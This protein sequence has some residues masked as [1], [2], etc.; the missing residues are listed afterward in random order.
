[1]PVTTSALPEADA[2]AEVLGMLFGDSTPVVASDSHAAGHMGVFSTPDD[3]EACL[4]ICDAN[5]ACLG[6]A[7]LLMVPAGGAKDMAASGDRTEAISEGFYEI[8]NICS[9]LYPASTDVPVTLQEL[10]TDQDYTPNTEAY[11]NIVS[12]KVTVPGYGDGLITLLSR[13]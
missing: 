8:V 5:F 12:F 9:T 10:K 3:S 13:D 1:M 4:M 7:K 2:V 6:A 11:P